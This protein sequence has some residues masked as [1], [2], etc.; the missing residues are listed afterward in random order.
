MILSQITPDWMRQYCAGNADNLPSF[1]VHRNGA[2]IGKPEVD[3]DGAIH[4]SQAQFDRFKA[5]THIPTKPALWVGPVTQLV[6]ID[7]DTLFLGG[8]DGEDKAS[9]RDVRKVVNDG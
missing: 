2:W 7:V 6:R 8:G 1:K 5:E 3:T 9:W 4:L